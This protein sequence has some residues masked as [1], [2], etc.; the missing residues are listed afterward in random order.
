MWLP[1]RPSPST[2]WPTYPP[3]LGLSHRMPA[4]T[5][6]STYS[7]SL[8]G[9]RLQPPRTTPSRLQRSPIPLWVSANWLWEGSTRCALGK[10]TSRLTPHGTI[11]TP[12]H[13]ARWALKPRKPSRTLSCPAP[14]PPVRDPASS[15]GFRTW[16][17][18]LPSGPTSSCS[19]RWLRSFAPL[20]LVSPPGCL[21]LL[22]PSVV[23]HQTHSSA[24]PPHSPLALETRWWVILSFI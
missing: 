22:L 3:S 13:P 15:K 23:L 24:L 17:L 5:S 14:R 2:L 16:A 7:S 21:H 1:Y 18:R 20:P 4:S 10:V 6:E 12:T 11:L 8:T 9:L 19:L